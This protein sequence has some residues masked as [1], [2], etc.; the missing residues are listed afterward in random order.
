[1]DIPHL[2]SHKDQLAYVEELRRQMLAA[3]APDLIDRYMGASDSR[4]LSRPYVR[5]PESAT[6]EG[7]TI[8]NSTLIR[9]IGPRQLNLPEK[10]EQGI[11]KFKCQGKTWQCS[12]VVLPALH[13]LNDGKPHSVQEL[14]AYAR[15][16]GSAFEVQ[17]FMQALILQGVATTVDDRGREFDSVG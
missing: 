1:M 4:A 6:P 10:S 14:E 9:L 15:G 12:A 2:S 7:Q 17:S 8:E 3:W 16:P 11:A 13:I 5:L